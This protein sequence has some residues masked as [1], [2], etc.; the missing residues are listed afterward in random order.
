MVRPRKMRCIR[1]NPKT[2]YFKPRGIPLIHLD[3]VRLSMDEIEA[4]RLK[5]V[6]TLDQ[7][8]CAKRMR[9]SQSTLQRIL[10]SARGKIAD[11]LIRGKAIRVDRA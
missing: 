10:A 7:T 4:V 2:T 1:F 8:E 3:E 11:A 5:D 6:E 9:I